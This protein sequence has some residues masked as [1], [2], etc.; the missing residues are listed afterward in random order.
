MNAIRRSK[1]QTIAA[2]AAPCPRL[3]VAAVALSSLAGCAPGD[4]SEPASPRGELRISATDEGFASPDSVSSGMVH[5]IFENHGSTIHEVMFIKLPEGMDAEG[6]LSEVRGGTAFPKGAIDYAGPGL[7]SPGGR[8]EQWVN[9]DPGRY[10]LACWFRRHLTTNPAR[11]LTVSASPPGNV[12]PPAENVILRLLDFRFELEGQFASGP[13]VVRVETIGP[14]LHEVDVFRLHQ[15]KTLA[16][17]R[18]WHA[19]GKAGPA[20]AEAIGGVLDSH[21]IPVTVWLRST[22]RP[23]RYVLWCGMDMVPDA[24]GQAKGATHAD[25]GMFLEFE[26]HR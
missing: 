19:G 17:L 2:V 14:S 10:L 21:K 25:A 23:G 13:Q 3:L 15:S 26:V 12:A 11:T 24:P 22:F 20:P 4:R 5:V 6:Y 7:T 1:S 16:D 9:L 18:A 8:V